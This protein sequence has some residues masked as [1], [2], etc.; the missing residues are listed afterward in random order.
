MATL[1]L[2]LGSNLGDRQGNLQMAL[3]LL[4]RLARVEAVSSLY[5]TQPAGGPA[6]QAPFYN[7][8]A[9]LEC[10]LEPAALLRFLK[11]IEHE[12]GR[13]PGAPR[14]GPRPIDL[15]VLLYDNLIIQEEGLEIPH[16]ALAERPFVLTPLCE[17]VPGLRHPV[18]DKTVQELLDMV[19]TAGMKTIAAPRWRGEMAKTEP[20]GL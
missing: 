4:T 2:G 16:P 14:W 11:N 1:Y 6:G 15:D 8:V 12:I 20:L 17:L 19:D 7:A 13:R 18:L 3:R 5:E 10:G 9:H